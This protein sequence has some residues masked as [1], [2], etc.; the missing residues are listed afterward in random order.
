MPKGAA[1]LSTI[2]GRVPSSTIGVA[3]ST[4]DMSIRLTGKPG[5]LLNT[6]GGIIH[7]ACRGDALRGA[8]RFVAG[9][10]RRGT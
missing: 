7:V 5:P 2:S 8:C 9:G 3:S 1:A 10:C 4:Q 6:S